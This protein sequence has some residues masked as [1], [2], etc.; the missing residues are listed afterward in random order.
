MGP[1]PIPQTCVNYLIRDPNAIGTYAVKLYISCQKGRS[2]V[3]TRKRLSET[4]PKNK[5]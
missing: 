4:S 2:L 3:Q 5:L 1:E